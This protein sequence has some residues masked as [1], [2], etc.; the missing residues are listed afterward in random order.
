MAGT[1]E[2]YTDTNGEHRWRIRHDNGNVLADS[3]E[4]YKRAIDCVDG[5]AAVESILRGPHETRTVES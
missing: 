5:L 4:G 1:V 2:L 3:A